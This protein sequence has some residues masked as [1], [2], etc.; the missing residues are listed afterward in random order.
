MTQ[1]RQNKSP[2][3]AIGPNNTTRSISEPVAR[4]V[5]IAA[6]GRCTF[7]N[8]WLLDD[9]TTGQ[10]VFIGQLAHVVGWDTTA[11]SPRGTEPL[12]IA[13]RNGADNLMLLCYD[14]HH[15]IDSRSLWT[16]YDSDRLRALK[17]QHEHRIKQLT[18][19]AQKDSA[20]VLRLVDT[21]HGRPVQLTPS[22]VNEALINVGR[23]PSY[24]LQGADEYEIDLRRFPGESEGSAT[25]WNAAVAFIEDRLRLLKALVA[26]GAVADLAVFPLAR[27]PILI[28]LGV[29]LD[30]TVPTT[31]YPKRRGG[32][33]EWGWAV[34][35]TAQRFEWRQ[36]GAAPDDAEKVVVI[37]SVS[38]S[39]DRSRIPEEAT[40][41]ACVYEITSV[42][43]TPNFD[44]VDTSATVDAF[45]QCWR[46][47]IAEIETLPSVD[48]VNLV[49]AVPTT[50]AVAIGRY[51][52]TSVHPPMRVYDRVAHAEEYV[53]TMELPR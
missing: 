17:R 50:V 36:V 8:R 7:C 35:G 37:F 48:V 19:L 39:V 18:A 51:I 53:F 49:P 52:N 5:W 13:D 42:G 28:A 26:E 1:P 9:D 45:G 27:I 6:G 4:R 15:V 3:V 16:I 40:A 2:N 23:F 12:P 32:S 43:A 31:V 10:P 22:A 41:G 29:L 34:T 38:G 33:E 44:L 11:G 47:L 30:D 20:T 14:Q 25:H 46:S 21:I 24:V